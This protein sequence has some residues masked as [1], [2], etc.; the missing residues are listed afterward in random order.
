MGSSPNTWWNKSRLPEKIYLLPFVHK[1]KY[2]FCLNS[3][4]C[5]EIVKKRFSLVK[6][7]VACNDLLLSYGVAYVV[8]WL[9]ILKWKGLGLRFVDDISK[10]NSWFVLYNSWLAWYNDDRINYWTHGFTCL[11][12]QMWFPHKNIT[13]YSIAH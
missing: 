3:W 10:L 5:T 2:Y 7:S 13:F 9:G 6:E 12:A 11:V 4:V 1:K 8:K